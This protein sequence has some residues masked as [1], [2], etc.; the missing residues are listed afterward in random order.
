[1]PRKY[2]QRKKSFKRTRFYKRNVRDNRYRKKASRFFKSKAGRYT[3]EGL[4]GTAALATLLLG[5]PEAAALD[6]AH[7]IALLL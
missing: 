5:G 7:E 2:N 6:A 1:M 3:T 4:V